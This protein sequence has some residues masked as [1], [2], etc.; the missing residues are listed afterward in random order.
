MREIAS[1]ADDTCK[2]YR[3]DVIISYMCVDEGVIH[4]ALGRVV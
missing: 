4:T 1:R 3:N 2:K